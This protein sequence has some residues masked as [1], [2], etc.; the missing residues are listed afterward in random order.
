[1]G[2]LLLISI[3]LKI[4][5]LGHK[6]FNTFKRA[7]V[8]PGVFRKSSVP[9]SLAVRDLRGLY[10]YFIRKSSLSITFQF[11]DDKGSDLEVERESRIKSTSFLL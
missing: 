3:A 6:L 10:F 9:S 5:S 1:M 4:V 7:E 8:S 2:P 11:S